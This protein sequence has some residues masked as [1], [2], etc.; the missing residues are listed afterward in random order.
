MIDWWL[1]FLKKAFLLGLSVFF[2]GGTSFGVSMLNPFFD[3]FIFTNGIRFSNNQFF[4]MNTPFA[5][6]PVDI[7]VGLAEISDP[8]TNR[9]VYAAVKKQ[10]AGSLVSGFSLSNSVELNARFL[11]EFF[12]ACGIGGVSIV[13][14]DVENKRAM[15]V[16]DHN[17]IAGSLV[18]KAKKP[19]DH[20]LRGVFA[21]VFSALFRN[22][23]DC[24][25]H[26]C[27]ALNQKTCEFIVKP[28]HEFDFSKEEPKDQ[29]ELK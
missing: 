11:A 9:A 16:V 1:F 10:V 8:A 3:R 23:L 22:D 27:I 20:V 29:L 18:N 21:G 14:L 15:L 17:P 26:Q 19:V 25:E 5:I 6:L 4:L 2:Y 24:V 28:V 12:S 13:H 7:L